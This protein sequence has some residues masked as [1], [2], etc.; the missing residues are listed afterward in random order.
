V[1]AAVAAVAL[2][3]FG[4]TS[5][6]TAE[7]PSPAASGGVLPGEPN[8]PFD[9]GA[10]PAE[11][12]S[13]LE[14]VVPRTW[15]YVLVGPDGRTANVYFTNGTPECYALANVQVTN[16]D[17]GPRVILWTGEIPGVEACTEEV[18]LYRTVV[19]FDDIVIGGSSVLDLPSGGI[20]GRS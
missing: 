2:I 16:D 15:D 11:V 19:V 13:D 10:I 20:G 14:N 1:A 18:R 3:P 8:P 6:V 12:R 7:D 5:L 4:G 17:R 9:D